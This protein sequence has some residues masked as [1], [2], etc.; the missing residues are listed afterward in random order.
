MFTGFLNRTVVK[1]NMKKTIKTLAL[2]LAVVALMSATS[3]QA[4]WSSFWWVDTGG[5]ITSVTATISGGGAFNNTPGGLEASDYMLPWPIDLAG[6]SSSG[7]SPSATMAGPAVTGGLYYWINLSSDITQ[8]F[9]IDQYDW[10][11]STLVGEAIITYD[12]SGAS[13]LDA[14]NPE[15]RAWSN[16]GFTA[17]DLDI[18]SVPEPT[19]MIAGALL[20]LPFGASTLRILRKRQTA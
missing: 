3:V 15:G 11:G 17:T 10:N 7:V 4:A 6:W 18:S 5:P 9:T 13:T 14:N 19:T 16:T 8:S 2:G 12:G 20:L 1:E